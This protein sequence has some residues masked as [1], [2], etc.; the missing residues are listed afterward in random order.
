MLEA[1]MQEQ[2]EIRRVQLRSALDRPG[3][4]RQ[5]HALLT[6]VDAALG[7]LAAGTFGRCETCGDPIESERLLADPTLR[8][9][10]DHLTATQQ[11]V[12]ERDLALASTVQQGL[13][14]SPAL[15]VGPWEFAY[16]YVPAHIVSGDY[17]DVISGPHGTVYF[18]VG[19]VA[20][21]GVSASMLMTQLHALFRALIPAGL[22]LPELIARTSSIFCDTTL[23]SHYATLACVKADPS[24]EV[25]ICNAGHLPPV[26]LRSDG[27]LRQLDP[28]G[29]PLGL[30]CVSQYST[31]RLALEPG[32]RI[33]LYTDGLSD[34][35]DREGQ[36][37]GADRLAQL[38]AELMREPPGVVV[39][40]V[41][42]ALEH[43][44]SAPSQAD[45]M[46]MM[47]VRRRG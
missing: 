41:F 17:C 27:D 33:V 16:R 9:C 25:E 12:L 45:D 13:L 40:Q 37:F 11:A 30:F 2:L 24:G 36:E 34:T 46:T 32:D 1:L 19:D 10:L 31:N 29:L 22:A 8:F 28:G 35:E 15:D 18:L 42:H 20:G 4:T 5:L 3:A 6:E 7:R 39:G 43:F 23:P 38:C 47:V 14:P 21:K 26:V 44:R